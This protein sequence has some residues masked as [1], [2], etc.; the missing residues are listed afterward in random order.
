M[1]GNTS[2]WV[3]IV[4]FS[5]IDLRQPHLGCGEGRG[6]IICRLRHA[7]GS[8]GDE[9]ETHARDEKTA[10]PTGRESNTF[11]FFTGKGYLLIAIRN[12]FGN[13]ILET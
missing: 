6:G 4:V 5:G 13:V 9:K 12:G 11:H 10:D 7:S 2:G 3:N 8:E 1:K